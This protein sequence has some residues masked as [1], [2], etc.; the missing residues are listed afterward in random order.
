MTNINK[1]VSKKQWL[2]EALKV[3]KSQD[4][5]GV[6]VGVLANRLNTSRSGFYWHFKDRKDLLKALLN[7]WEN[8]YTTIATRIPGDLEGSPEQRLLDLMLLIYDRKLAH[9]DLAMRSWAE[10]DEM[11]ANAMA[12]VINIR[13]GYVGSLF[14]EMGF[15]GNQ[16]KMRTNL[17]V[18]YHS[19]EQTMLGYESDKKQKQEINLR[20]ELFVEK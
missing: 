6:K 14:A 4:V 12:R 5:T 18:C 7:Y 8:E 10:H 17:F 20:H 3:L 1:R 13:L 9:Y 2:E 16:L 11:A 19:W 15:K